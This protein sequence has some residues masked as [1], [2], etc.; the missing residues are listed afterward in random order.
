MDQSLTVYL[1]VSIRPFE[2]FRPRLH[3]LG[4]M[5]AAMPDKVQICASEPDKPQQ[6]Q[7]NSSD[8][9][10]QTHPI[11]FYNMAYTLASWLGRLFDA[12][13]SLLPL[14]GNY[15]NALLEQELPGEREGTLTVR[16]NRTGS[17]YTIPIVRNSVPAMGFRQ[18]CVDRAG[19]SPRQQFEDGLRLIDPGYRNT[20]VKMSSITY[21]YACLFFAGQ[22]LLY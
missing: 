15:I 9:P 6:N 1:G 17:K 7:D 16:D 13:K 22:S 10:S 5:A 14:Q 3:G 20:A 4:Q 21:M 18:I 19:K 12:G 8:N 2:L 11:P